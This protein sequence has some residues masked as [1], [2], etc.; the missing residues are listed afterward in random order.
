MLAQ[1]LTQGFGLRHKEGARPD[2]SMLCRAGAG[3]NASLAIQGGSPE[4]DK[5]PAPKPAAPEQDDP[6]KGGHGQLA[7]TWSIPAV[8]PSLQVATLLLVH[9]HIYLSRATASGL[10]AMAIEASGSP[11]GSSR[12]RD[13]YLAARSAGLLSVSHFKALAACKQD[14]CVLQNLWQPY[15]PQATAG[16]DFTA[17]SPSLPGAAAPALEPAAA[18]RAASARA[19]NSA[20]ADIM[21]AS[22]ASQAEAPASAPAPAVSV[23]AVPFAEAATQ[24]SLTTTPITLILQGAH[25]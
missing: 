3:S 17:I 16:S 19:G 25:H 15:Q 21:P 10:L 13:H 23:A 9:K 5:V 12:Q 18:Q 20:A 2:C 4:S 8:P 7:Y 22:I 24:A 6:G 1:Y 11:P 14:E